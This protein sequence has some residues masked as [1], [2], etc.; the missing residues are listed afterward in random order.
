MNR[1]YMRQ[2]IM[3]ALVSISISVA[4]TGSFA[5]EKQCRLIV[6][7]G[8]EGDG[9]VTMVNTSSKTGS[10]SCPGTCDELFD[11]NSTITL[12]ANP[13]QDNYKFRGWSGAC[14]GTSDCTVKLD[15]TE[16]TVTANFDIVP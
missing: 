5:A 12:K 11:L 1:I 3:T 10:I 16:K 2:L 8:G 6:S 7:I 4:A 9:T 14:T 13:A 15:K